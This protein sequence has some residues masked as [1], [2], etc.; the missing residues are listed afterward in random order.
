MDILLKYTRHVIVLIEYGHLVNWF[1][2]YI[3]IIYGFCIGNCCLYEYIK[4]LGN[5]YLKLCHI[6]TF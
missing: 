3:K 6:E 2:I 4:Y 5:K 1:I